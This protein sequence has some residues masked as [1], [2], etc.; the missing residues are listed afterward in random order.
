MPAKKCP[1]CQAIYPEEEWSRLEMSE[2]IAPEDVQRL[3]RGWP[4]A[5]CIEVRRCGRCGRNVAAKRETSPAGTR[6]SMRGEQRDH[7][8]RGRDHD[9]RR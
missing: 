7:V 6:G 3:V 9:G 2:R 1:H 8:G 4:E 5:L